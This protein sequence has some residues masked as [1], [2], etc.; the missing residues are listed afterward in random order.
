MNDVTEGA[1]AAANQNKPWPLYAIIGMVAFVLIAGYLLSPKSEEAKLAWIELLGTT[2]Q[3]ILINPP[4][5]VFDGQIVG[6]DGQNWPPIEDNTWK[7]LVLVSEQCNQACADRLS[8]LHAMRIRLN[9]DAKRLT[10]GLLSTA[11]IKLPDQVA[12]FH[13]M[14]LALIAD[15]DLRLKLG[16]TNIP[17]LGSDP[18][19]LMMNPIDV[20][21]MAY[22]AGHSAVEMLEDFEHLLDLA[23]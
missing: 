21:M 13:D 9:R 23:H 7:L 15:P 4:V 8:E 14:N 22:G 11:A 16:E 20:F 2:N 17:P 1:E 10:V 3:G 18:V 5:E 19:V 12:E 6:N